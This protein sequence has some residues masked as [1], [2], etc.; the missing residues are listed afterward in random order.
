MVQ[1]MVNIN[2]WL[3]PR[4][5]AVVPTSQGWPMTRTI[6]P[7]S[8]APFPRVMLHE[9]V[10]GRGFPLVNAGV[11]DQTVAASMGKFSHWCLSPVDLYDSRR[12]AIAAVQFYNP[13]MELWAH[14][15]GPKFWA[16]AAG[17]AGRLASAIGDAHM[18]STDGT[19]WPSGSGIY[20]RIDL[21]EVRVAL[22]S[23][24][25]ELLGSG[26]FRGIMVDGM[27]YSDTW[28]LDGRQDLSP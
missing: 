27:S 1:W 19:P 25:S 22:I 15:L 24:W 11:I 14:A 18:K 5:F 23:A 7:G 9:G 13:T 28:M 16:S 20:A 2:A 6:Q 12:D 10:D 17:W 26:L 8:S 21:P 4:G 3:N